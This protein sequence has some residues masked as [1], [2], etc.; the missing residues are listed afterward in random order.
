MFSLKLLKADRKAPVVSLEDMDS[1]FH[2]MREATR[3]IGIGEGVIRYV[4]NNGRDFLKK[5]EGKNVKVFF[6]KWC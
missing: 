1:E 6:I 3:A 5:F 4:R 2:S